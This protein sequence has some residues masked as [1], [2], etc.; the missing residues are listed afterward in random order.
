MD[1]DMLFLRP[2]TRNDFFSADGTPHYLHN[3]RQG[4]DALRN[5][6][7]PSA[8]AGGMPVTIPRRLPFSPARPL[9]C[10]WTHL[11]RCPAIAVALQR[12]WHELP[13][14]P[15]AYWL[16]HMPTPLTKSLVNEAHSLWPQFF[17]EIANLRCR[18]NGNWASRDPLLAY[19]WYAI[20]YG[21]ATIT[22][23]PAVS[24]HLFFANDQNMFPGAG[25]GARGTR[26]EGRRLLGLLNLLGRE[27]WQEAAARKQQAVAHQNKAML[28]Q[29]FAD[30]VRQ[31]PAIACLNDD[32]ETSDAA[33]LEQ[34]IRTM[35]QFIQRYMP[36]PGAPVV[37]KR[38]CAGLR[39]EV[40]VG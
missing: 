25:A 26:H 7:D 4:P 32:F 10:W 39:P 16:S 30:A 31:N 19:Q 15:G 21:Y 13:P 33:L 3:K 12:R 6:Q 18:G 9:G 37:D 24:Q 34:Q 5:A 2:R 17:S 22:P 27:A 8:A 28:E 1:D 29:F 14:E 40:K 11:S 23:D 35:H 38:Q 36:Q 20:H